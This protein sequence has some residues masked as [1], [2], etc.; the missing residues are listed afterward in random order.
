MAERP[1][2][3]LKNLVSFH[4]PQDYF[5]LLDK[6]VYPFL[7]NL[8]PNQMDSLMAI[9]TVASNEYKGIGLIRYEP[10]SESITKRLKALLAHIKSDWHSGYE[11]QVQCHSYSTAVQVM[12]IFGSAGRNDGHD[13]WRNR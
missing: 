10:R 5:K 6:H 2:K 9:L 4:E 7:D 8:P 11:T 13:S 1:S 3:L 12:Q